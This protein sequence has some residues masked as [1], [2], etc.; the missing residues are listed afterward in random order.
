MIDLAGAP[1]RPGAHLPTESGAKRGA[2]LFLR[3]AI[4]YLMVIWGAD[5]LADPD[6]G[7]AVSEHF[8]AGMFGGRGLMPVYGVAQAV[9]GLLLGLGVGRKYLYPLIAAITGVTL[10][11]VWKSVV[12]PWGWY[13]EGSNVLFFPSLIIFAAVLALWAFR[14]EDRLALDARGGALPR[15][16][17][18]IGGTE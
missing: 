2:I 11:G 4:A 13:L 18:S 12:D 8:Y 6:H 17:D 15:G 9:V 7:L 16:V 1:A 5:K 14:D 10:L 3:L